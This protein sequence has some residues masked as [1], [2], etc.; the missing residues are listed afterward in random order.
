MGS[1]LTSGAESWRPPGAGVKH[2]GAGFWMRQ[3]AM[4]WL[5]ESTRKLRTAAIYQPVWKQITTL[6]TSTAGPGHCSLYQPHLYY[7]AYVTFLLSVGG[8]GDF[9]GVKLHS[10]PPSCWS[11]S[12]PGIC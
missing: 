12:L 2:L 7:R 1:G 5:Q 6:T 3:G 11:V 9:S 4:V 10:V 8:N